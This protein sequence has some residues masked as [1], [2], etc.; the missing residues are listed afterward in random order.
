MPIKGIYLMIW[1]GWWN[2]M[3]LVCRSFMQTVKPGWFAK[4]L[5]TLWR[6]NTH[7]LISDLN[8]ELTIHLT[9]NYQ[10]GGLRDSKSI[11]L[12]PFNF[13]G[14]LTSSSWSGMMVIWKSEYSYR[15]WSRYFFC[16]FDLAT[17]ILHWS[18]GNK[19]WLTTIF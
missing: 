18:Y 2:V 4:I 5:W 13:S 17:H 7:H 3:Q 9:H 11:L 6:K 10:I 14:P 19:T 1:L 12:N 8:I 15:I 16:I